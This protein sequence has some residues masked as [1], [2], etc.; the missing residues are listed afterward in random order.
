[1]TPGIPDKKIVNAVTKSYYSI[2]IESGVRIFEYTPGFL[3][4]KVICADDEIAAVGTINMDFRSLYLHFE[5]GVLLYGT[6]SIPSIKEDLDQTILKSR[7]ISYE[8]S[9]KGKAFSIMK[10]I[11]RL[12]RHYYRHVKMFDA[13]SPKGSGASFLV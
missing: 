6:D 12:L 3:H 10:A 9:E 11:L 2:L 7:E 1:M 8:M 5:N 4:A 13:Y